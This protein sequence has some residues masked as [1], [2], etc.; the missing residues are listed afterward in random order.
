[1]LV[2]GKPVK[3]AAVNIL[4]KEQRSNSIS[5]REGSVNKKLVGRTNNA[6]HISFTFYIIA[7]AAKLANVDSSECAKTTPNAVESFKEIFSIAE[8]EVAKIEELYA[9]A[10]YDNIPATHYAKQLVNLFPKNRLLIEEL[11][12]DLLIFA[13][14]DG[15]MTSAKVLFLRDVVLALNFNERFF[16]RALRKHLLNT[17]PDPFILLDVSRDISYI[18]LKKKYRNIANDWHPDKFSGKNVAS[19]LAAIAR[20]QFELYSKA[21]ETIKIDRGFTKQTGS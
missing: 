16:H 11:V 12:D 17:N 7:I 10:A 4:N 20:E 21:Y 5:Q 18:D 3:Y 6:I 15:S 13:D 14:A 19:E 8:S 2:S 9:E 1:M